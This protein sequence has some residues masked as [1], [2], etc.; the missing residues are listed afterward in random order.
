MRKLFKSKFNPAQRMCASDLFVMGT[1][2]RL[3]VNINH[4]DMMKS[5][6]EKMRDDYSEGFLK[7]FIDFHAEMLHI[8]DWGRLPD[9]MIPLLKNRAE[10]LHDSLKFNQ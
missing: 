6:P 3:E 7:W 4:F 10:E 9:W 1:H 5:I 8:A 2:I